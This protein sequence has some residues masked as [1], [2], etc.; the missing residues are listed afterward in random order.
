MDEEAGGSNDITIKRE[1]GIVN[2]GC[3]KKHLIVFNNIH[4]YRL[5]IHGPYSNTDFTTISCTTG[6]RCLM[7]ALY[8]FSVM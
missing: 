6:T 2:G 7:N 8:S 1:S 4:D 5:T 3:N